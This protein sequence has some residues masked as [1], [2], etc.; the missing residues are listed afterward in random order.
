MNQNDTL[1][2]DARTRGLLG[3][4]VLLCCTIMAS[5]AI[6]ASAPPALK[7]DL[8]AFDSSK[9]SVALPDGVSLAYIDM[10]AP[11]GPAGFSVLA[12]NGQQA[13]ELARDAVA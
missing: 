13:L 11:L 5:M 12:Q 3:V 8:N 6:A 10:G 1:A 2:Q 7:I 4:A 9:T